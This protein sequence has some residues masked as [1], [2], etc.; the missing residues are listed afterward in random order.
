MRVLLRKAV[1]IHQT[2]GISVPLPVE[3]GT[4]V[5]TLIA[6]LFQPTV[7]QLTLF[8]TARQMTLLDA[9]PGLQDVD[10]VWTRAVARE[11]ES[12]TRFAQ[13]RIRPEEVARELEESSAA[14]GDA[15]AVERFVSA[16][17]ARLGAPLSQRRNGVLGLSLRQLPAAVAERLTHRASAGD[18][19]LVSFADPAPEGAESLGRNHPLVTAL[20]EYLLAQ[21]L[22]PEVERPVASRSSVIQTTAVQRRTR[23]FLLRVRMLIERDRQRLPILAE[24]LVVIG[25]SG[26][27]SAPTW[28]SQDEALALLEEA[29]ASANLTRDE[30]TIA[31]RGALDELPELQEALQR[32]AAARAVALREAHMRVRAQ[33]GGGSV[34]VRH[35]DPPDL[36]GLYILLPARQQSPLVAGQ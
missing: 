2:L 26:Q 25:L 35:V 34:R 24:E 33:I 14:L 23:L 21:A 17:C 1:R 5:E 18:E 8:D 16:A 10:L 9:V 29:K 4:V 30:R 32:T 19:L 7:E 28:L 20:T 15:A 11:Q 12:R 36:L 6:T 27:R 31:L 3:S 22:E 13:R